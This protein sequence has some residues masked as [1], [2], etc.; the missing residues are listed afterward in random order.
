MIY[1]WDEMLYRTLPGTSLFSPLLRTTSRGLQLELNT[2]F[3]STTP[4]WM[5]FLYKIFDMYL[6]P[7]HLDVAANWYYSHPYCPR[8]LNEVNTLYLFFF[9]DEL[10]PD[11]MYAM[12]K[13]WKP[14]I[15]IDILEY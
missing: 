14:S 8:V 1:T 15:R 4:C 6:T 12:Y 2:H 11:S 7:G 9:R 5:N 3:Y 10:K 13:N